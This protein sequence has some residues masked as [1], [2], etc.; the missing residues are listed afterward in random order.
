MQKIEAVE[1]L[2]AKV[3]KKSYWALRSLS[4]IVTT[5]FIGAAACHMYDPQ[6]PPNGKNSVGEQ[7]LSE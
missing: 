4:I 3:K 7:L 1:L 2:E 6:F 5:G